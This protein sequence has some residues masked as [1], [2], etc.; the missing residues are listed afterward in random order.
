MRPASLAGWLEHLERLH[1]SVIE[2]GLERVARVRDA[3]GLAPKFP[4]IAVAGT[5]GKGSSCAMLEAVFHAAGYK[6][7]CYTSPHLIRYNE[8]VRIARREA[9]DAALGRAFGAVEQARGATTLTYFEFGTLAAVAAFVEAGVEVAVLEVG[10]GGRLDA[11][12]A[13]DADCALVTAIDLDHMEYL[14]DTREKIGREKAGI[15]RAGRPAVCSD[16]AMP[17]SVAAHAAAIGAPLSALGRDFGFEPQDAQWSYWGP[18]GRR[19]ALPHPALRG[20]YQLANAS[21]VITVLDALRDRLPVALQD[22]RAGLLT[23]EL[24]GRFQVLPGRPAVILD[25]AHNPHAARALAG[26]LARMGGRGR[27]LAVCAMLRDKDSTGVIDALAPEVDA[28]FVGSTAG[29]RGMAATELAARVRV[30]A[31]W[32]AVEAAGSAAEA[33]ARACETAGSDDRICVF[34]SFLTVAEVI[35][36]RENARRQGTAR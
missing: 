27:T 20:A 16:P 30:R 26:N 10:L 7:G 32:A 28:W 13:F 33:Y 1:P 36:A 14:G 17:A 35:A 18:G 21:G 5:N 12:N 3:L 25:V 6:V 31:P 19:S 4:V 2:L 34:G 24:P 9:D 29:P 8:R 23:A 15:F 11:V 22:L